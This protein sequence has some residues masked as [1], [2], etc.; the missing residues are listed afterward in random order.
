MEQLRNP[1]LVDEAR[2]EAANLVA[3]D[4]DLD[5]NPALATAVERLLDRIAMN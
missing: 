5:R 4:P 3:A 1:T 2:A